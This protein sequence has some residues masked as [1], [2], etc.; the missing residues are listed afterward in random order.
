MT[1]AN[2][3][4]RQKHTDTDTEMDKP[5]AIDEILQIEAV[6]MTFDSEYQP[7]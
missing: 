4:N 2:D 5:L 3:F 1:Y 7:T 6:L